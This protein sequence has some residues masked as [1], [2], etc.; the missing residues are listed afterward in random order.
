MCVCNAAQGVGEHELGEVRRFPWNWRGRVQ[1]V[2]VVICHWVLGT[3][4]GFRARTV[5]LL[6]AESSLQS[7]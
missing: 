6:N 7:P 5:K 1:V 3:E 4:S 2:V